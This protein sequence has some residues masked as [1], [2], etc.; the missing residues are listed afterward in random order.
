MTELI[1]T[2]RKKPNQPR[3]YN[4]L[5]RLDMAKIKQ[6]HAKVLNVDTIQ[7]VPCFCCE[8]KPCEPE[9]CQKLTEWCQK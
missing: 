4:K 8:I 2:E 1:L 9:T 5:P 3:H 6:Q 7:D